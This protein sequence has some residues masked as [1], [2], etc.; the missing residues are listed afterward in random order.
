M[1]C[2]VAAGEYSAVSNVKTCTVYVDKD[3]ITR[4][5]SGYV[6]M[7]NVATY[8]WNYGETIEIEVGEG[9]H[10]FNVYGADYVLTPIS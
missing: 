5:S 3:E 7:Q 6:E 1:G 10:L 8:T 9:E 2:L 4:N